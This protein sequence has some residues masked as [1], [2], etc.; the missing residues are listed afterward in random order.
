MICSTK[1]CEL[2]MQINLSR[3]PSRVMRSCSISFGI[4]LPEAARFVCCSIF[5]TASAWRHAN[6][7]VIQFAED[8]TGSFCAPNTVDRDRLHLRQPGPVL[9]GLQGEGPST[10]RESTDLSQVCAVLSMFGCVRRNKT[11]GR[12]IKGGGGHNKAKHG[13]GGWVG[14]IHRGWADEQA[15]FVPGAMSRK[16]GGRAF[17]DTG[18]ISMHVQMGWFH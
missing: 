11:W 14:G 5:C 4:W 6:F 17:N 8:S 15:Q 12:M 16:M 10:C 13:V 18:T 3:A 7:P 1:R 2:W 9:C